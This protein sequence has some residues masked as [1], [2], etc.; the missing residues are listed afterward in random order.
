M[1]ILTFLSYKKA[2][3]LRYTCHAY[4]IDT[5]IKRS[6]K[7]SYLAYR[8]ASMRLCILYFLDY[9]KRTGTEIPA[10]YDTAP[11]A[12]LKCPVPT[13]ILS[14]FETECTAAYWTVQESLYLHKSLKPWLYTLI[15]KLS[16]TS[17][18]S[19]YAALYMSRLCN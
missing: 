19:S 14:H 7:L 9:K 10:F 5:D 17:Q 6:K 8:N 18:E 4:E 1:H 11:Q 16:F 13:N 2:A 15:M 12:S 3:T